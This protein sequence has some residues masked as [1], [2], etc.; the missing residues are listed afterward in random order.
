[1]IK[2]TN[3]SFLVLFITSFVDMLG[4]GIVMPIFPLLVTPGLASSVLPDSWSA[5]Q[6]YILLGWIAALYPL[7]QF[8]STPILGQLSDRFG[9]KPVLAVSIFG[10]IVGYVLF[11]IGL[12]T[13]NIPLLLGSRV[14]DGFTGGN[15]SVAQA[16]VADISTNENRAKNFGIIGVA[17]GLGVI[18]GP[19][20][21]GKLSDSSVVSWFSAITPFWFA[22]GVATI[23]LLMVVFL[24]PETLKVKISQRLD[25][26]RPFRNIY[27]AFS[28]PGLRS[29]MPMTFLFT[30]A[31]T[32]LTTFFGLTLMNKFGFSASGIGNYF[33]YVGICVA[34]VQGGLVAIIA[35]KYKD[36]QVLR[37]SLFIAG[38]SLLGYVFV[39][40]GQFKWVILVTPL[41]ALGYGLTAA[42]GTSIVSRITPASLQGE[43]L[44]I[45]ASVMALANS[46]P[47]ILSGYIASI[48]GNFP[49]IAAC[50]LMFAAGISFWLMFKPGRDDKLGI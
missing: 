28:R 8:I 43:A 39:P 23:N 12:Y 1:M 46:I 9:R 5:T 27:N 38:V 19:I 31:F 18:F 49:I 4:F 6:G 14:L 33:G 37:Y 7:V 10:T 42:F 26:R 13:K 17:L 40:A 2:L 41:L 24:L 11:A 30:A 45:N 3:K 32:F 48:N 25:I 36:Y 15:M 50:V 20:L 16:S 47:A 44:G 22:A 29:V 35:K 34:I 21:G